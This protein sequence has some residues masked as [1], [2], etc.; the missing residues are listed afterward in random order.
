VVVEVD[1]ILPE[2]MTLRRAHDIGEALQKG[3]EGFD[4]V[5]RAYVHVDW[6]CDHHASHEHKLV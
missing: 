5:L 1:I 6:E 2:D 4:E 3:L